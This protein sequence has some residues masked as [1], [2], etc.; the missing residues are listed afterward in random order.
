VLKKLVVLFS[1]HSHISIP[2]IPLTISSQVLHSHSYNPTFPSSI[3]GKENRQADYETKASEFEAHAKKMVDTAS[4]L[5]KSG[6]ITD[7]KLAN[8]ILSTSKK[9]GGGRGVAQLKGRGSCPEV[10]GGAGNETSFH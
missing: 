8:D 7:R 2:C 4:S 6:I 1:F 10:G 3:P 5:A 9:V